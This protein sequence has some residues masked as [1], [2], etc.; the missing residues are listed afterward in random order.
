MLKLQLTIDRKAKTVIFSG[1]TYECREQ[2][3]G[4]GR[5]RYNGGDRSWQVSSFDLTNEQVS[6][7][8]PGVELEF[9]EKAILVEQTIE[10]SKAVIPSKVDLNSNEI[11]LPPSLSVNEL[12]LR[13]GIALKQTF[14][15]VFYLRGVISSCNPHSS[16]RVYLEVRDEKEEATIKG[17]IWNSKKISDSLREAGFALSVD[18]PVMFAVEVGLWS[19]TSQIQV[20][21]VDV[22]P[23]YTQGR[24]A[25][26]RDLTNERLK[27]E[28][29]FERNKQLKLSFL[30]K[31]LGILTSAT[32]TVINDFR[33]SLDVAEFGFEL[34]WYHV[35]VQGSEAKDDLL[36]GLEVLSRLRVDAILV[37]RGGGSVN[38]LSIFNNYEIAKGICLSPIPVVSAI[39][40][41]KD[42]SSVQDVSN[43]AFGVPKDIGRYFA[44]IVIDYRRK[45]FEFAR[46]VSESSERTIEVVQNKLTH[47]GSQLV[48]FSREIWQA[49]FEGCRWVSSEIPIRAQHLI[50]QMVG[51][52]V[53]LIKESSVQ[54]QKI[55]EI[56]Q[57]QLRSFVGLPK[58]IESYLG[59]LDKEVQHK[60]DLIQAASPDVQLQR[61]FVIVEA[62]GGK[63][64]TSSGQLQNGIEVVLRFGDGRK[65]TKV[66]S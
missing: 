64:L 30:P 20:T 66:V 15:G 6:E 50:E 1:N 23:E 40:H 39:G 14:S 13:L 25:A 60:Y 47:L 3:K 57:L 16:G 65:T 5:A 63:I 17:V 21:I 24:L 28:G 51:R 33:A 19:K 56:S 44:D 11:K 54:A 43:L 48:S 53:L 34:F 32:G 36:R 26:E 35:R 7:F 22:V 4:L 29:L 31:R 8:F 55:L 42:Q 45:I 10:S 49:S 59:N 27:K 46:V 58:V 52:S 2:I 12:F 61:G 9:V 41:Q 37:F 18:L 38:D 62:E